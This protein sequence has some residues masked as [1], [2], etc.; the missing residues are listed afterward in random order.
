MGRWLSR[1]ELRPLLLDNVYGLRTQ[2][3]IAALGRISVQRV[4]QLVKDMVKP[5]PATQR[6]YR[7]TP[8][9]VSAY[10]YRRDLR[11]RTWD[12]T[13]EAFYKYERGLTR[14]EPWK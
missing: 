3:E 5:T 12:N 13:P 9:L 10:V 11:N 6:D 1:E 2:E 4:S 14:K 7:T 8:Q